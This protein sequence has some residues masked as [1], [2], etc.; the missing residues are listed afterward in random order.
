MSFL[1]QKTES[2]RKTCLQ[3]VG[4]VILYDSCACVCLNVCNACMRVVSCTC[5]F[6]LV[7]LCT[8]VYDRYKYYTGKVCVCRPTIQ[9]YT[10]RKDVIQNTVQTFDTSTGCI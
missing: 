5:A 8:S 4:N 3:K 7:L 10:Y 9:D 1:K 2:S 6:L